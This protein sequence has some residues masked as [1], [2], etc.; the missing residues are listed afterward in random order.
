V[1]A[2]SECDW[3]FCPG[4]PV[5]I[6]DPDKDN[7]KCGKPGNQLRSFKFS[8][9]CGGGPA[10]CETDYYKASDEELCK[11]E[12]LNDET[13]VAV[14]QGVHDSTPYCIG[15]QVPLWFVFSGATAYEK[16]QETD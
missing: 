14:S 5:I 13:C 15:C 1:D 4:S 8:G 9:D 7:T 2:E 6:D 11:A 10:P 12:C 3:T 16:V